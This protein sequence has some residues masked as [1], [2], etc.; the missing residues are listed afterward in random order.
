MHPMASARTRS[1]SSFFS[2]AAR[3]SCRCR[4]VGRA[5]GVRDFGDHDAVP[6]PVVAERLDD[7]VFF[8]GEDDISLVKELDD[9][10]ECGCALADIEDDDAFEAVL[11]DCEDFSAGNIFPQQHGKLGRVLRGL[12]KVFYEMGPPA[13]FDDELVM[14]LVLPVQADGKGAAVELVDLVDPERQLVHRVLP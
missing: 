10:V 3:F 1:R 13:G 7:L 5:H 14:C 2:A 8:I 4:G 6:E 11:A 12:G 9:E